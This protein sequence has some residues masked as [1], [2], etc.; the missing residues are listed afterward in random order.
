MHR[1]ARWSHRVS[2][3]WGKRGRVICRRA[4]S[5]LNLNYSSHPR[6][7]TSIKKDASCTVKVLVCMFI[8]RLGLCFI[9]E[10]KAKNREAVN[11]CEW[12]SE[13]LTWKHCKVSEAKVSGKAAIRNPRNSVYLFIFGKKRRLVRERKIIC[14]IHTHDMYLLLNS[15][16][17][18]LLLFDTI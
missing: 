13:K 17:L 1:A 4:P 18:S 10:T 3:R 8:S 12:K 15:I 11:E 6:A 5:T 14:Y 9:Y 2:L 16:C 7:N